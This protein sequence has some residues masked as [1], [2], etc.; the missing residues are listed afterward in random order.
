MENKKTQQNQNKE[1][2]AHPNQTKAPVKSASAKK[3]KLD[4]K[5]HSKAEK[6]S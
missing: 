1:K 6:R 4:A 3:E 5:I 2:Q